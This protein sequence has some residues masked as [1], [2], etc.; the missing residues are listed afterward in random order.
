MW[1][2]GRGLLVEGMVWGKGRGLLVE[3]VGGM[4]HSSG[5]E[6]VVFPEPRFDADEGAGKDDLLKTQPPN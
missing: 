6:E 4:G 5:V 2:K 3:G 1:G